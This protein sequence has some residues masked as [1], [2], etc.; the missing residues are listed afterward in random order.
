MTTK[1]DADR[2]LLDAAGQVFAAKGYEGATVR[3]ICERAEVNVAGVNYY[4]R[5][6]ERLYIETVKAACRHQTEQFPIP[7]WPP[8]TPAE[9]KLRDFVRIFSQRMLSENQAPWH[10]QLFLREM[11][12]PTSACAELVRDT[13]RPTAAV[14]GAILEEMFP[15]L[16]DHKRLA[17][18]FSIVGQCLFYRA[19]Q[20]IVT[21]LVGEETARTFNAQL[22]AEHVTAFSLAALGAPPK[23]AKRKRVSGRPK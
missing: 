2:R 10:R 15:E 3:E 4:F 21:L 5:D 19:F 11:A 16:P 18:A 13:V 12:Q 9:Q 8:G 23:S 6:K 20:P 7:D 22:V 14:L 17:C 1:D